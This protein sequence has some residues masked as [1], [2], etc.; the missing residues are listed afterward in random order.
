MIGEDVPPAL[1][2]EVKE[3]REEREAGLDPEMDEI[4]LRRRDA[5]LEIVLDSPT[6]DL[7]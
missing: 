7:V 2:E 6:N 5:D 1:G 4:E 3:E